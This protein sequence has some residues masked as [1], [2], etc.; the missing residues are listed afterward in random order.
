MSGSKILFAFE[1]EEKLNVYDFSKNEIVHSFPCPIPTEKP[2]VLLSLS[3]VVRQDMH[4]P[5]T[6]ERKGV[7]IKAF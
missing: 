6:D 3:D 7:N 5:D 4:D 2:F 1:G